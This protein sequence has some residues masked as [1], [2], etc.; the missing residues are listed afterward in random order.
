MLIDSFAYKNNLINVHPGEKMAFAI[1]TMILCFKANIYIDLLII[2]LMAFLVI[3]VAGIPAKVY[4]KL[5]SIPL[6]FLFIAIFTIIIN[7]V[8]K[9][10]PCVMCINIF[11]VN[12]GITV[13]GIKLASVLFFRSLS[14]VSCLYFMSLTTPM[15]E[16]ISVLKK[17]KVPALF[18]E[19]MYLIYRII[20]ILMETADE[21]YTSQNS[22]MGYSSVKT[23]YKSLGALITSLFIKSLRDSEDMFVALEARGYDG[24]LNIIEKDY[25]ISKKNLAL[26]IFEICLILF[27]TITGIGRV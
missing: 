3:A 15:I 19:F 7:I 12:L 5:M 16:V 17:I 10:T 2:F 14:I 4:L 13:E 27:I 1:A 21:I 26:I 20:F 23:G 8:Q 11:N 18:I 6:S 24:D 25:M 22:R 9:G